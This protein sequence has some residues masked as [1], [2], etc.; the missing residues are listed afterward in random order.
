MTKTKTSAPKAETKK[1]K[2]S[3]ERL[4]VSAPL[5]AGKDCSYEAT[6]DKACSKK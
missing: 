6:G 2:A 1:P 3:K 4:Q 5:K